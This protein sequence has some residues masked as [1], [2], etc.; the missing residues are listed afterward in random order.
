MNRNKIIIICVFFC[1]KFNL[2]HV[3]GFIQCGFSITSYIRIIDSKKK[4]YCC[5]GSVVE[6]S[7]RSKLRQDYLQSVYSD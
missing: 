5:G 7:V 3:S 6:S 1:S 2:L 4:A